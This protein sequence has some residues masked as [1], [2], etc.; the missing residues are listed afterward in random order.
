MPSIIKPSNNTLL[1]ISIAGNSGIETKV[2]DLL[3]Q[4]DDYSLEIDVVKTSSK[5]VKFELSLLD[6]DNQLVN[7]EAHTVWGREAAI[8]TQSK[9]N[10]IIRFSNAIS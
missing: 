9:L 5:T 7:Y 2:R 8:K 1:A 10:E 4:G 6:S 3:L